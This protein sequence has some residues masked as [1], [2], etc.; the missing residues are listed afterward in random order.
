[1]I[2]KDEVV[3]WSQMVMDR[4]HEQQKAH[5]FCDASI[6]TS[7]SQ[8]P[9]HANVLVACVPEFRKVLET[10]V[11]GPH[12]FQLPSL[13]H[14]VIVSIVQFIYSGEIQCSENISTKVQSL[15]RDIGL[16]SKTKT[17]VN[18]DKTE[19]VLTKKH[20][21][22][23]LGE[24]DACRSN[25]YVDEITF[26]DECSSI[27]FAGESPKRN[28]FPDATSHL[29]ST[30][31][32]FKKSCTNVKLNID[33]GNNRKEEKEKAAMGHPM[34]VKMN[35]NASVIST[36]LTDTSM[37]GSPQLRTRSGRKIKLTEKA[38][39]TQKS[40]DQKNSESGN[41]F[42]NN[43]SEAIPNT[44]LNT[45]INHCHLRNSKHDHDD[46]IKENISQLTKNNTDEK[47]S[48]ISAEKDKFV[49]NICGIVLK[50]KA[51]LV[52]HALR[53]KGK[54]HW[55]YICHS[56]EKRFIYKSELSTHE[57]IHT[58]EKPFK[59]TF[60]QERF[61]DPANFRSH[62][63]MCALTVENNKTIG[64]SKQKYVCTEY[65]TAVKSYS[66]MKTHL[67]RQKSMEERPHKCDYC[68]HGFATKYRL[69]IHTRVHSGEKPFQCQ[70]CGQ[71]Y[72]TSSSLRIHV[73][74]K[75]INSFNEKCA[76]CDA[77]FISKREL[78]Q[79]A[80][81]FHQDLDKP[82][83]CPQCERRFHVKYSL[84]THMRIHTSKHKCTQCEKM[85]QS[86]AKLKI[87]TACH[88][89]VKPYKCDYCQ[90]SY[91][92]QYSLKA[93]KKR[94]ESSKQFSCSFCEKFFW[95]NHDVTI[96]ERIHTGEK[97]YVC[98]VCS[99]RF[100]CNSHLRTH[101]RLHNNA[102]PYACNKCPSS[103]RHSASLSNH[104]HKH[105][106]DSHGEIDHFPNE[107]NRTDLF[108]G[109]IKTADDNCNIDCDTR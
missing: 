62:V 1:M 33:V 22:F 51:G 57:K 80:L 47:I 77:F 5:Q 31:I 13:D 46:T 7:E 82:Y 72:T 14:D 70:Y 2:E 96:H 50:R 95:R 29:K 61:S 59:C 6:I 102:K 90:A 43:V 78:A 69:K 106:V 8:V 18:T 48:V 20:A 91:A 9:C 83:Q 64:H 27:S 36:Y 79:H 107:L 30:S 84:T 74:T 17:I 21:G 86:K 34:L 53:H 45:D 87:H 89:T 24:D 16:I 15:A 11:T 4:L 104:R 25:E 101:E 98:K 35:K 109:E 99:K 3:G 10:G 54:D 60:C 58:V 44:I 76:F 39:A 85:F 28:Q 12:I 52:T 37:N 41:K 65:G 105:T 97:P 19:L 66:G 81:R 32:N 88:S 63:K 92:S 108:S 23:I 68:G 75:H 40:D 73:G 56:C 49:C 103:F 94:H 93:H 71:C 67:A 42:S 100:V 55:S 38:F 26:V